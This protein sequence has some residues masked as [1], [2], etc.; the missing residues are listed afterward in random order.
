MS[1]LNKIFALNLSK[2]ELQKISL[3]FGSDIA[4]FFENQASIVEGRGEIISV[5]PKFAPIC[6]LLI[7]PKITLS[8][9]E[10]FT[11]FKE[12]FSQ[13]TNAKFLQEK[14][15]FDL[16]KNFS[17]DLEKPAI[18]RLEIINQILEQLKKH[19]AKIAKMSGSGA[20]CFAIFDDQK[21]LQLAAEF[22]QKN[23]PN[24]FVKPVKILSE[25]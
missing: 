6:A 3:N 23:F 4:F 14:N 17:N 8:T 9:K 15:I 10:V 20:S 25:I 13:K 12:N 11:N 18:A 16:L 22:F 2:K 19:Q 24:F 1:A 21:N 7:N 5:Y